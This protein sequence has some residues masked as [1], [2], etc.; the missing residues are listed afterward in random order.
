MYQRVTSQPKPV[1]ALTNAQVVVQNV[2]AAKNCGFSPED[3]KKFVCL[4]ADGDWNSLCNTS[5]D[6]YFALSLSDENRV[7]LGD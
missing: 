6:D 5:K 3:A 7:T 4:E 2:A 1:F